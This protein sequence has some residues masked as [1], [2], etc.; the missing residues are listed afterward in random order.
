MFI[1]KWDI[2]VTPQ[3]LWKHPGKGAR[4]T[5]GQRKGWNV[6]GHS[7]RHDKAVALLNFQQLGLPAQDWHKIRPVNKRGGPCPSL[8]TEMQAMSV[9]KS[10]TFSPVL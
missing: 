3:M 9:G 10:E 4:K 5:V 8:K 6:E 2:Y 1:P 7:S